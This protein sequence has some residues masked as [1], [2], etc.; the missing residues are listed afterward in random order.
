MA[1]TGRPTAVFVTPVSRRQSGE[2][3]V[4]TVTYLVH[5]SYLGSAGSEPV[6]IQDRFETCSYNCGVGLGFFMS[7]IAS[8][9]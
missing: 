4:S 2:F 1:A 6:S 3:R 7:G 8:W 9:Y 5:N